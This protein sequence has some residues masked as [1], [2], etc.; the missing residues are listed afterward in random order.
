MVIA[1]LTP[2]QAYSWHLFHRPIFHHH[3]VQPLLPIVPATSPGTV[4]SNAA[5]LLGAPASSAPVFVDSAVQANLTAA[6]QNL[7]SAGSVIDDL[8]KKNGITPSTQA[9]TSGSSNV[10]I[11]T[12]VPVAP[13]KGPIR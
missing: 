11:V 5:N 12:G 9:T 6:K 8:L 2:A 3:V 13:K 7:D 4:L 10:P 1:A